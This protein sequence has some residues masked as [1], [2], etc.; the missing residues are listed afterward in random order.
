MPLTVQKIAGKTVNKIMGLPRRCY[1][2]F[3]ISSQ[4]GHLFRN[5]DRLK[6]KLKTKFLAAAILMKIYPSKN[7][8]INLFKNKLRKN[9]GVIRRIRKNLPSNTLLLL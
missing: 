2:S 8:K 6:V 1:V 4:I 9:I 7:Y 3:T 5:E